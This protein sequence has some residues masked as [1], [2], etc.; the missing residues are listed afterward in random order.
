MRHWLKKLFA[1][2]R[3]SRMYAALRLAKMLVRV[4]GTEYAM[5]LAISIHHVTW[6]YE[7]WTKEDDNWFWVHLRADEKSIGRPK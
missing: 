4:D 5:A 3:P 7:N 2:K 6:N 1:K